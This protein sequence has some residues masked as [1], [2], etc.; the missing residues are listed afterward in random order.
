MTVFSF[1]VERCE[2]SF[3]D[4][5]PEMEDVSSFCSVAPRNAPINALRCR[6]RSHV[7]VAI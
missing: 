2:V 1:D 5:V 4:V 7:G 3:R 6:L